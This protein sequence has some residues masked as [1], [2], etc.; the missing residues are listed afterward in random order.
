MVAILHSRGDRAVHLG[1]VALVEV[2]SAV[3]LGVHVRVSCGVHVSVAA[4]GALQQENERL[5]GT[6]LVHAASTSPYR[7]TTDLY[8]ATFKNR[9]PAPKL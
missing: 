2:Q 8:E 6:L 5:R 4:R 7:R 1:A 3:L 9:I